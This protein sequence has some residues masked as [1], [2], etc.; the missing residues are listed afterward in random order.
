MCWL[1]AMC[2]KYPLTLLDTSDITSSTKD[3]IH[4]FHNFQYE[5]PTEVLTTHPSIMTCCILKEYVL[6]DNSMAKRII[7]MILA[8]L[9]S[10]GS[11]GVHICINQSDQ[12]MHQFYS[13][14]GFNEFFQDAVTSTVYLGRNF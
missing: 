13:K 9:R 11:Y 14:L 5:T 6:T 4:H 10:N 2:L 3:L 8:A 1:P 7:T 12:F